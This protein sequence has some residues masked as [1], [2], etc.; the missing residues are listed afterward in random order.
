MYRQSEDLINLGAYAAGTGTAAL[1]W[2]PWEQ[3]LQFFG[4]LKSLAQ[5]AHQFAAVCDQFVVLPDTRACV[6]LWDVLAGNNATPELAQ[7]VFQNFL[8]VHHI[9]QHENPP[10][11]PIG[12]DLPALQRYAASRHV[13]QMRVAFA[14]LLFVDE[15]AA[16]E[17]AQTV[18][19]DDKAADGLRA[20]ALRVVLIASPRKAA[21]ATAVSALSRHN[22]ALGEPALAYLALGESGVQSLSGG[23][24]QFAKRFSQHASA[25]NEKDELPKELTADHVRPFLSSQDDDVAAATAYLLALLGEP[26]GLDRLIAHWR[27]AGAKSQVW[28][29]LLYEAIAASDDARHVPLLEEIYRSLAERPYEVRE[30][31][32]AIR[33]MHGPEVLKLRKRIRDEVG[34]DNLR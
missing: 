5:D 31:Y 1:N 19:D 29:K 34:M 18:F 17:T 15:A 7:R 2:L 14:L 24:F 3:R 12:V 22:L 28:N 20:D 21:R 11:K 13:P 4:V 9:H 8:H 23:E 27:G 33:S 6:P 10:S 26:A 30:L 25:R 16:M 32:W